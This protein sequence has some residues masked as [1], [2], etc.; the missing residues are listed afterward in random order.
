M[1]RLMLDTCV[2]VELLLEA[3][4]LDKNVKAIPNTCYMQV[5]RPPESWLCCLTMVGCVQN[6]G[7]RQKM[8]LIV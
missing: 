1:K 5:S 6:I 8:S 2:V 7:S 3:K 4:G